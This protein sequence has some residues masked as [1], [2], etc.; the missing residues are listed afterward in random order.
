MFIDVP[1]LYG[2]NYDFLSVNQSHDVDDYFCGP[3]DSPLTMANRISRHFKLVQIFSMHSDGNNYYPTALLDFL[4]DKKML[5][6]IKSSIKTV[7][8]CLQEIEF[9]QPFLQLK[10]TT[11]RIRFRFTL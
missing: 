1:A 4:Y 10:N 2:R 8:Q 6:N 9:F 5:I 3:L 11:E 7:A